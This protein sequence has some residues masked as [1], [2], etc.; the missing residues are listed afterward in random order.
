MIHF[1]NI[2]NRFTP[3]QNQSYDP[4]TT[5]CTHN[6]FIKRFCDKLCSLKDVMEVLIKKVTLKPLTLLLTALM[7][8]YTNFVLILCR[9]A[10]DDLLNPTDPLWFP[11]A[12]WPP[13]FLFRLQTESPN[14]P[15]DY[16]DQQLCRCICR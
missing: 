11:R 10:K 14:C 3:S 16:H 6:V 8:L 9:E 7:C 12:F 1:E 15:T 2:N 4:G 13:F 5:G